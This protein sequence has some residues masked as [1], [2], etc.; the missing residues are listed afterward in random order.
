MAVSKVKISEIFCDPRHSPFPLA[1]TC[2]GTGMFA[3]LEA[4]G[5]TGCQV[6]PRLIQSDC[7][8][9]HSFRSPDSLLPVFVYSSCIIALASLFMKTAVSPLTINGWLREIMTDLSSWTITLE[10]SFHP[11]FLSRFLYSVLYL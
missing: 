2:I 8:S 4:H 5:F 10:F 7:C 1:I 9:I 11:S 6:T 3:C